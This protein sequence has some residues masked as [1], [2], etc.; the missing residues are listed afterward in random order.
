VSRTKA[1]AD[2]IVDPG[3]ANLTVTLADYVSA[4][5]GRALDAS[6]TKV[7]QPGRH[8]LA[9]NLQAGCWHAAHLLV[10]KPDKEIGTTISQGRLLLSKYDYSGNRYN[11][12]GRIGGGGTVYNGGS[13]GT[14][15]GTP[16][17]ATSPSRGVLPFTGAGLVM[18]MLVT[19]GGLLALGGALLVLTRRRLHAQRQ[20]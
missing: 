8:R 11:C 18:P 20:P 5:N 19:G 2:F 6:T 16:V 4:R 12:T 14:A 17:V 1:V 9:I 15:T 10:G 13:G 7:F 3:C